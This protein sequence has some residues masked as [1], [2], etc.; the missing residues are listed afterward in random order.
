MLCRLP[1]AAL[2]AFGAGLLASRPLVVSAGQGPATIPSVPQQPPPAPPAPYPP[3]GYPPPGYP[4]PGFYG[5]ATYPYEA[6]FA[7]Q[8][9]YDAQKKDPFV[10]LLLEILVPGVGS[11]YAGHALGAVVTWAFLIAGVVLFAI[12]LDKVSDH[13]FL[14]RSN[15]G[16]T[17]ILLGLLV[18]AGGRVYG[19]VDSWTSARDHNR[20][21]RERLG[22]PAFVSLGVVP[23]RT[24]AGLAAGPGLRFTF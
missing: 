3:A 2:C 13:G 10:A 23:L 15:S 19:F 9:A 1:A 17:E 12:G 5:P 14:G 7:A 11:I 22:L 21:L 4:P 24:S 20:K 16:G 6:T 8:V 18:M